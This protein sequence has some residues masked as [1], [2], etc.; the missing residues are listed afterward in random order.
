MFHYIKYLNTLGPTCWDIS[1]GLI[2]FKNH[3]LR[4]LSLGFQDL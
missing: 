4:Y 2:K 1:Q 3:R